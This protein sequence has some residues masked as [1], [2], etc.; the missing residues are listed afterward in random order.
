MDSLKSI[1]SQLRTMAD[2]MDDAAQEIE[3]LRMRCDCLERENDK[4]KRL[5]KDIFELLKNDID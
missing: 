3:S 1:A 4:N 2:M 5:K